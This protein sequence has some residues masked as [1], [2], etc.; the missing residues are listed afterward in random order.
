MRL[1]KYSK[2]QK[3]DKI[4]S[5]FMNDEEINLYFGEYILTVNPYFTIAQYITFLKY[6]T[7]IITLKNKIFVETRAKFIE[8][9]KSLGY[10]DPE[11]YLKNNTFTMTMQSLNELLTHI[12]VVEMF[13]NMFLELYPGLTEE[14]I[15]N[16]KKNQLLYNIGILIEYN[17][18]TDI[19]NKEQMQEISIPIQLAKELIGL[20]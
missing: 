7:E 4:T 10:N 6:I 8:K 14:M 17:F 19:Q 5:V 11:E 1:Q 9:A 20:I 16:M 3:A 13:K 2:E 12:D 18:F 15:L